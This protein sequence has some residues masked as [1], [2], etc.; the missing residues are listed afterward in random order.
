MTE[1][2]VS[3]PIREEGLAMLLLDGR[4]SVRKVGQRTRI[5]TRTKEEPLFLDEVQYGAFGALGK[6]ICR[7]NPDFAKEIVRWISRRQ[8]AGSNVSIE[9]CQAE[10]PSWFKVHSTLRVFESSLRLPASE[11]V[12]ELQS[13]PAVLQGDPPPLVRE[14]WLQAII[15]YPQAEGI[16]IEPVFDFPLEAEGKPFLASDYLKSAHEEWEL[17]LKKASSMQWMF[18]I[19]KYLN[20]SLNAFQEKMKARRDLR[21]R[22]E[23]SNRAIRLFEKAQKSSSVKVSEPLE[24]IREMTSLAFSVRARGSMTLERAQATLD[25]R[26]F[27]AAALLGLIEVVQVRRGDLSV[28]ALSRARRYDPLLVLRFPDEGNTVRLV[29]HWDKFFRVVDGRRV[30]QTLIHI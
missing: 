16:Y 12:V 13:E 30:L 22:R 28:S 9:M 26:E 20:D 17:Y 19:E 29:A 2:L 23:A 4:S 7:P 3:V 11:V 21:E 14:R 25:R 10:N 1:F 18:R 24:L 5:S 6:D 15:R 8:I 27:A